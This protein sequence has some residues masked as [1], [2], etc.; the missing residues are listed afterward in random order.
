M[1]N[2][3]HSLRYETKRK[4]A[5]HDASVRIPTGSIWQ[6]TTL[7]SDFQNQARR[8]KKTIGLHQKARNRRHPLPLSQQNNDIFSFRIPALP[9]LYT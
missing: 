5:E 4:K 9:P 8:A 6:E 2:T 3:H 7:T 1:L